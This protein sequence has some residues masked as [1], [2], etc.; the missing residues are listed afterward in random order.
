MV[1]WK[2]L[3]EVCKVL[4]GKRLTKSQLSETDG[5]PVLHGGSTPM[6]FYSE[7]NRK[8][9]T[10]VVVNTGNAGSVFFYN[11]EFWSSDA[12]F[13]LYPNKEI[14]D[15][16]LY[17]YVY[18]CEN[19][20]KGK[21][22]AGAMPTIDSNAV[23]SLII[24]IPSLEEQTRIVGILDT[25]TSAIDNLKEQIAQRRKQYEYYRDQ[26]LDL[27]GKPGVEWFELL[28]LCD[29]VDYRGKTPSKVDAGIFLVTAKN[30]RKGYIDYDNSKEYISEDDYEEVMHRGK[31]QK[32]DVL[33][34][35]E[36][37]LGNVAQIDNEFIALAQR[38]IKY[39]PKD[40]RLSSSFLKYILLGREFQIRL[41]KEATG[42]TAKGIKGSK[43]HK[44]QIPVPALQ[45]QQRIV[46]ILDTF[47]ASIQNLEA[48]LS[49]REKQYEYYRNKLLT[50]E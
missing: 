32:G 40:K 30:I 18:G 9:N 35:T 22:R 4:R 38:V 33:I 25:F 46:S 47:E 15:K 39:R 28:E 45:K 17:L 5:Y 2:K 6:G 16:F 31:P 13:S 41:E 44:I 24:P 27:E 23:G 49:Q 20:L 29:Y 7:Y 21:I 1:E 43:L 8:A 11:K 37:P 14:I 12:C 3:G 34:T 26:L 19:I 36:A 10:T 42:A 48:Q 50:F